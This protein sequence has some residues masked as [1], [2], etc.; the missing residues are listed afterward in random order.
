MANGAPPRRGVL[1]TL[2]GIDGAG[3]TT[4][5]RRLEATLAARGYRIVVTREP[6][7]TP[8]GREL[9][10]LLLE[11]DLALT[12]DAELLL[13]LADRAEHVAR[14]IKPALAAGAVVL[15]DRF[16]DSTLA[17]Q[18]YGRR[19]DVARL[20]ELD[21]ASRD[22]VAPD[23][24]LLL[25]CPVAEGARRRRRALDRYQALDAAFQERVRDGFLA[26]AAAAPERVRLIDTGGDLEGASA[27]IARVTL[28]WLARRFPAGS[29][30]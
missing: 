9:R 26:L 30:A 2:E 18:G 16:S 20:R 25:D 23:L 8:L 12:P 11:R 21:A 14:V 6:G 1:I 22:G 15:C 17:Y 10:R 3:K 7:G 13:F 27:E 28:E 24:T 29:G 19:A 5:V 4:Q